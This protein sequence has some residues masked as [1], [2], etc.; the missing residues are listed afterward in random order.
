MST[1]R[2][3]ASVT[4]RQEWEWNQLQARQKSGDSS[5]GS[6]ADRSDETRLSEH[7]PE[8]RE[9]SDPSGHEIAKLEAELER[10]ERRLQRVIDQ[11]EQLLR[12]K[13]QQLRTRN[14][15]ESR[16]R[17][18]PLVSTIYQYVDE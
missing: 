10:K 7:P 8:R 6:R 2:P 17:A 3:T 15:S 16:A 12:E 9:R 11:Y 14:R 5:P 13:N 4:G 1:H 18:L